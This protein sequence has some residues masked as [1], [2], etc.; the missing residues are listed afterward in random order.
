MS[1][2]T[3]LDRPRADL[4]ALSDAL[5]T[6]KAAIA[7]C[8][9]VGAL[10]REREPDRQVAAHGAERPRDEPEHC[11]NVVDRDG[12]IWTLIYADRTV[13]LK[14]AK[15][16][17][18]L[19]NLLLNPG[20]PIHVAD[21]IGAGTQAAGAD[22][23]LDDTAK[24]A[25]RERLDDLAS[26]IEDADAGHDLARAEQARLERDAI[27]GELSRAVGLCGRDRLLG[28]ENERARKRVTSRIRHAIRRIDEHHPAL[29]HHLS[30][31]VSTG[32]FCS[33]DPTNTVRWQA[34]DRASA[35]GHTW[36]GA[37]TPGLQREEVTPAP[38]Q[39]R[40]VDPLLRRPRNVV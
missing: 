19:R 6:L 38:H 24:A 18:D 2:T 10:A 25:Y 4:D 29:G 13:R 14:D 35:S 12:E 37:A 20:T 1:S 11:P 3:G 27:L 31:S 33:Y 9:R 26:D 21:L 28:D 23:V 36:S 16:F 8:E 17:H 22:P 40:G 7:N 30:V 32:V 39:Q 5:A 15:G 34:D